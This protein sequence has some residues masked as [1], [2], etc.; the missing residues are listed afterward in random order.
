MSLAAQS[1][2]PR[3][4]AIAAQLMKN[5]Q[6]A[7]VKM[8][9]TPEAVA[10]QSRNLTPQSI[11]QSAQPGIFG[12]PMQG[13]LGALRMK[14]QETPL[15][16]GGALI[17]TDPNALVAGGAGASQTLVPHPQ[18]QL[19]MP[20]EPIP[21]QPG[22]T[23]QT[24]GP[25]AIEPTGA[26]HA[27]ETPAT[28]S[29]ETTTAGLNEELSAGKQKAVQF[30]NIAPRIVQMIEL[31]QKGLDQGFGGTWI[32]DARRLAVQLGVSQDDK[33]KISNI[34]TLMKFALPA[35]VKQTHSLS[36]RPSQ[37]EFIG[38]SKAAAAD[39]ATDP[40]AALNVYRAYLIDGMNDIQ[41][42]EANIDRA[43]SLETIGP[44][45]S[46]L[47]RVPMSFGGTAAQIGGFEPTS[48]GSGV[49]KDIGVGKAGS[50]PSKSIGGRVQ[51]N[52]IRFSDLPE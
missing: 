30:Q 14:P 52:T 47:Y 13:D 41:Q 12:L 20:G 26:I 27:V 44:K 5:A 34:Q 10:G 25:I 18:P 31:T 46:E 8:L 15:Q 9:L 17:S 23:N 1:Q 36:S 24:G 37:L 7:Q 3:I 49:W 45:L 48:E 21:G 42:H 35:A 11:T 28:K 16:A 29:M 2:D 50:L 39:Q 38:I 4:Q 6:E 40:R 32:T 33:E 19:I 43:S 22:K 51:S